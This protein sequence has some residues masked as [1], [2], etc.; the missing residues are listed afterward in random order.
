M[1]D[2][3]C[4]VS[5]EFLTLVVVYMDCSLL[6]EHHLSNIYLIEIALYPCLNKKKKTSMVLLVEIED[7]VKLLFFVCFY[8]EYQ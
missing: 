5:I 8:L 3:N 2:F 1:Y 4:T 7:L 6:R